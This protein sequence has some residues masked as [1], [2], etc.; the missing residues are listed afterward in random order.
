[1]A[2][3]PR[4]M[5]APN[6]ARRTRA[7]H[8][9]LPET[10]P[11]IVAAATA[12]HHAGAEALHAHVRDAEARHVLDAGLYRE[13]VAEMARALP[14]MPVQITT[15]AVGLYSPA[16]QRALVRELRPEGVS[17]ALREMWP[18]PGPDPEAGRFYAETEDA[19]IALQHIL[20]AP[21]QVSRL[22]SLW[23]EGLLPAPRQVLFVLGRYAPPTLARPEEL[24][25]F[26][27]AARALPENV[28]WAA[29]AFGRTEEACLL[30]AAE[31]DGGMRIGFENNIERPDGSSA[32][33]N[34][35]QV[36]ALVHVLEARASPR[37][38]EV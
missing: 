20:Y 2:K 18:D 19:G 5:L 10:I 16:E 36:A 28:Q 31:L 8:P 24:D 11:Q 15:E 37:G 29:C 4:I 21:D 13:L 17:V 27:T 38:Q 34:A 14:T 12:A 1:M 26:L 32:E 9:A 30:R 33:D 3:L 35:G 6:G 23:S 25:G 7:D 22:A